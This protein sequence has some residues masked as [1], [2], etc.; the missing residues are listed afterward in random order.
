MEVAGAGPDL[1]IQAR[2]GFKVVVEDV[3]LGVD[4]YF[5][6]AIL[7]QEVRRQN[8]DCGARRL[9][10]DLAHHLGEVGGAAVR[11][12]IAVD[13]RDHDVVQ[14]HLLHGQTDLARFFRV[15]RLGQARLDV[16]EGAGPRAGVA[17]D[18][19]G[20]VLLAP[21]L[22]DVRAGRLFT[23]RHQALGA[24]DVLGG[25]VLA[26]AG[27]LHAQ[28]VGFLQNHRLRTILLLRVTELGG[29][30]LQGVDQGD[31][32]RYFGLQSRLGKPNPVT[33]MPQA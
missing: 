9:D 10:A 3:R 21:A 25:V 6:R 28:P 7:A 19:Q 30:A 32:D 14:T 23:D 31:H 17:H 29:L 11:H 12:V 24:D 13:R 2:N 18:H 4:H 22:A 33:D 5:G 15:Q 27:R 20:G 26:R 8:L 16:A 1:Q